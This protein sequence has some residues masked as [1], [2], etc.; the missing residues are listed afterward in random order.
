[1]RKCCVVVLLAIAGSLMAQTRQQGMMVEYD[2]MNKKKPL[3]A[4]EIQ[5]LNAQSTVSDKNGAFVLEFRTLKPGDKVQVRSIEKDGY[6]IFNKEAIEQWNVSGEGADRAFTIMMCRSDKFRA[7]K[8][9]YNRASS[10]SYDRQYKQEMAR[11]EQQLKDGQLRQ[12]EYE[13]QLQ[14]ISERYDRQL[15]TLDT[16]VDKFARL[17]LT[18]LSDSEQQIVALV[19]EGRF[20][21]ALALYEQQNLIGKMAD[22]V[23]DLKEIQ[24]AQRKLQASADKKHSDIEY[25]HE[26]ILRQ[27]NVLMMAGGEENMKKVENLY[28]QLTVLLPEDTKSRMLYLTYLIEQRRYEKAERLMLATD[29][30]AMDDWQKEELWKQAGELYYQMGLDD[31]SL[32]YNRRAMNILDRLH[33]PS[34]VIPILDESITIASA[35]ANNEIQM[36]Q[37]QEGL[38]TLARIDVALQELERIQ[39]PSLIWMQIAGSFGKG[40]AYFA[41]GRMEEALQNYLLVDSLL[42]KHKNE[43]T[44]YNKLT[45]YF[46]DIRLIHVCQNI[47][48]IYAEPGPLYNL[49]QAE[50]YFTAALQN[51]QR[52][53]ETDPR[54]AWPYIGKAHQNLGYV[55]YGMQDVDKCISHTREALNVSRGLY[56]DRSINR[57]DYAFVLSNNGYIAT[58]M[59]DFALA[60]EILDEAAEVIQPLDVNQ[61]AFNLEIV[62]YVV[63][64]TAYLYMKEGRFAEGF[65]VMERATELGALYNERIS[66][67]W[68]SYAMVCGWRATF[69]RTLGREDEASRWDQRAAEILSA[70]AQ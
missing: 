50:L 60:R 56:A 11:V 64:N 24:E 45:P 68:Q 37:V 44:V 34:L 53:A 26:A 4:V 58:E 47:G 62:Y 38:A 25:L 14:Q 48:L 43:H 54:N 69:E 33:T 3:K 8:D 13:Q 21:E 39:S 59:G 65:P 20:D 18:R 22:E 17:D 55:A 41:L 29:T 16:Y 35:I 19:K 5:V 10:A 2:L 67:A 15:Q 42:E 51:A 63:A 70:H 7:L 28:E 40:T 49:Q 23:K 46:T 52:L 30:T 57:N 32:L 61:T 12:E 66:Y 36:G 27:A 6:E 1:M 31:R 9:S